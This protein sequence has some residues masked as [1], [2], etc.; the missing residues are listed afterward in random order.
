MRILLPGD[1]GSGAD[2]SRT[3]PP[4]CRPLSGRKPAIRGVRDAPLRSRRRDAR[5]LRFCSGAPSQ[6]CDPIEGPGPNPSDLKRSQRKSRN[7]CTSKRPWIRQSHPPGGPPPFRRTCPG[8]KKRRAL[9]NRC[10]AGPAVWG[11]GRSPV[12]KRRA[13]R[14]FVRPRSSRERAVVVVQRSHRSEARPLG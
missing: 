13:T 4:R 6:A 10:S 8:Q 11:D 5:G 12:V 9:S 3:W 14:V 2:R 7:F 1:G